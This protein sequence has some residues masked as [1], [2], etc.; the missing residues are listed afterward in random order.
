MLHAGEVEMLIISF[1][2]MNL[3]LSW[4][5]E[6][7]CIMWGR[8]GQGAARSGSKDLRLV[9]SREDSELENA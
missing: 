1:A 9:L 6:Q 4:R 8:G 5:P 2:S 7:E 3:S